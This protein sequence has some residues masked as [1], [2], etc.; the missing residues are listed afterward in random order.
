MNAMNV[1]CKNRER[2]LMDGNAEDWAS[3]EMHAAQCTE[4]ADE[5]RIWKG[6]SATAK[7]MR[8]DWEAPYLWQKIER[9]LAEQQMEKPSRLGAWLN[10][11]RTPSL[12][13][14]MAAAALLL[15]AM[16]VTVVW[17]GVHKGTP[18]DP[19]SVFLKNSAVNDVERA[20][21]AYQ[22]AIDKLDAQARPQIGTTATPLMAS[23]REK[24]LI[25]DNAISEL[26]AE[27]VQNPANAHLRRQL[28]AMY[29]EKQE[30]LQQV[31]EAKP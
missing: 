4:C 21:V 18:D 12:S 29:Q 19:Q 17:I 2:I 11:L 31:L 5:L 13:W 6:I 3:L 20:E 27:A 25:L 10:A 30:T 26:H 1:T 16:T 15:V 7:E 28:L 14:Q 9:A 24:L 23:Y 8:Q 22:R